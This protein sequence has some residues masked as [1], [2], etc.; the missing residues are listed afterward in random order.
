MNWS[1]LMRARRLKRGMKRRERSK[2]ALR[3]NLLALHIRSATDA[4]RQ[5]V[6]RIG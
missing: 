2:A 4:A 6:R 5:I 1:D 3:R